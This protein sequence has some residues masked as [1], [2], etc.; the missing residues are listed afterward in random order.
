MDYTITIG[1]GSYDRPIATYDHKG[2]VV[3]GEPE[4]F[5]I[6]VLSVAMQSRIKNVEEVKIL[7]EE[8]YPQVVSFLGDN[9]YIGV[10]IELESG[11]RI[12]LER[13]VK[14]IF[15]QG[16]TL[17]SFQRTLLRQYSAM[18]LDSNVFGM[19]K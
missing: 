5:D 18:Q 8:L 16:D 6:D 11:V 4:H 1:K 17:R 9:K 15:S 13:T 14:S 19:D 7:A 12:E 3:K 2:R 10:R